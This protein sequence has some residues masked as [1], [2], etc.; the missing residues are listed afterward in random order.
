MKVLWLANIPSPYSVDFLNELGKLCELTVLFERDMATD[1]DHSWKNFSFKNFG[2][3]ILQGKKYSE[4]KAFCPSVLKY[5]RQGYD[6]VVVSNM[7]TLTGMLAITYM[8]IKKKKY[9]I[10]GD[11]GFKKDGYGLKEK[12]KTF[13]ISGAEKCLSTGQAHDEYY[14]QY[15]ALQENIERIPFTSVFEREIYQEPAN[16]DEKKSERNYVDMQGNQIVLAIG[17][18]IKRKGFDILIRAAQ[19]LKE[20]TNVYILGGMVT[21]EYEQI[22]I[23]N[24]IK[25]V[26]FRE[27][28]PHGELFHY[29]RAADIFVL[30]TREDIWGLVINEAMAHGL[31][32][33]TTKTCMAGLELVENGING[34]LVPPEDEQALVQAIN[35]LLGEN[36]EKMGS[37]SLIKMKKYT[38]ENTAKVHHTIFEN[39]R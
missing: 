17:Q 28:V 3:I 8:R 18:F 9:V 11:G 4:D 30:P 38:F 39:I 10:Q 24:D 31:P 21:S 33:V 20:G 15:G 36:L 5:L 7:A 35:Q 22:I 34:V 19:N 13:L 16:C 6:I 14:L 2:G 29:F 23:Q 27:F 12:I 37:Q 32:I 25:N 1:R 26:Y